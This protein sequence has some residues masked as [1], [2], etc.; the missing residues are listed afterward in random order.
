M[1]AAIKKVLD[2]V[3]LLAAAML[4]VALIFCVGYVL[5]PDTTPPVKL[6]VAAPPPSACQVRKQNL[7]DKANAEIDNLPCGF[8]DAPVGNKQCPQRILLEEWKTAIVAD[9][10][11]N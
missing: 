10:C 8:F 4:I 3:V 5:P 6:Q 9:T 2:G 11:S 7:L 1:R